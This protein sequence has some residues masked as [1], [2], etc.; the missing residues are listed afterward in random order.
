MMAVEPTDGH[1]DVT[2]RTSPSDSP[3]DDEIMSEGDRDRAPSTVSVS[4]PKTKKRIAVQE[5]F[6]LADLQWFKSESSVTKDEAHSSSSKI[7]DQN[8]IIVSS[9]STGPIPIE[10]SASPVVLAQQELPL[11]EHALRS[12]S[13]VEKQDGILQSISDTTADHPIHA[14]SRPSS[15]MAEANI[16]VEA[17]V[18]PVAEAEANPTVEAPE[19]AEGLQVK[20]NDR[21]SD[22]PPTQYGQGRSTSVVQ[23]SAEG[24]DHINQGESEGTSGNTR[25]R[26]LSHCIADDEG[27]PRH[28]LKPSSSSP[29]MV[30]DQNIAAPMTD[31]IMSDGEI[32]PDANG[33]DM[34]DVQ[35][36][37]GEEGEIPETRTASPTIDVSEPTDVSEPAQETIALIEGETTISPSTPCFGPEMRVIHIARGPIE[38]SDTLTF[39]FTITPEDESLLAAWNS[40]YECSENMSSARCLSL[41]SYSFN[42]CLE[43]VRSRPDVSLEEMIQSVG[44][45]TTWPKDGKLWA[46]LTN[47]KAETTLRLAPPFMPKGQPMVDLSRSVSPGKNVVY[48]HQLRDHSDLVFALHLHAPILPQ[49]D[50]LRQRRECDANWRQFLTE[51]RTFHVPQFS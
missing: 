3:V 16:A 47:N 33:A 5:D 19:V 4:K 7:E 11:S 45:S 46:R 15:P 17:Q 20:V 14:F 23:Q 1:F 22:N 10:L 18:S 28:R 48:I 37:A 41:A 25:K 32:Q 44:I 50:E 51:M 42:D 21:A 38:A 6:I 2:A 9:P 36:F 43:K 49:L 34:L 30:A 26:S 29:A 24:I 13:P 31:D 40:R 27:P 12:A 8:D 35:Q 39:E